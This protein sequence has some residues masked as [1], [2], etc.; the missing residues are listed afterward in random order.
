MDAAEKKRNDRLKTVREI[1]FQ[2]M[3]SALEGGNDSPCCD[4]NR[5]VDNSLLAAVKI[6]TFIGVEE[7]GK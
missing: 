4:L 7:D 3:C 2:L 6:V 1:A 5:L